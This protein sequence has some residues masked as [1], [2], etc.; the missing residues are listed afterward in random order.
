MLSQIG[1]GQTEACKQKE[2]RKALLTLN[3]CDCVNQYFPLNS[4]ILEGRDDLV[5]DGLGK[6]GL[7]TLFHLLFIAH[8]AVKNGLEL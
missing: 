2:W 5:D 4:L 1:K 3:F 7:F 8:P 6:V